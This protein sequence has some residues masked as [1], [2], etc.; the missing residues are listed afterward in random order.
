MP[1]SP[2]WGVLSDASRNPDGLERS[3][4]GPFCKRNCNYSRS[5]EFLREARHPF[6]WT[7][8]NFSQWLHEN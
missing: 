5:V 4:L 6:R 8:D 3:P 7:C 1:R 2:L